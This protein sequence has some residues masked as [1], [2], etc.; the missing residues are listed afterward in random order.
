MRANGQNHQ[1]Q[2]AELLQRAWTALQ[3]D[4]AAEAERLANEILSEQSGH[5]EATKIAAS[6]ML[7]Q[8]RA[9]EVVVLLERIARSSRDPEVETQLAIALRQ[10]G[11]T[12]NSLIWLKR[13][14]KRKPPFAAAFHELGFVLNSLR[15]FDEAIAVLKQGIEAA[16]MMT[17][18][19]IQLGH[20]YYARPDRE[21][22]EKTF[23][24]A[25][26]INPDN[27]EAIHGLGSV[28]VDKGDYAGAAKLLRHAL[29]VNQADTE[30]RFGLA[31]CM[32]EL[33]QP[34]IAYACLRAATASGPG[35]YGIALNALASSG[36][37]RFWLRPSDAA[38]FF[39]GDR[40]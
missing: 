21:N 36:H 35:C 6:A 38:K 8:G 7:M 12:S 19:Q 40:E 26:A 17:Y 27:P 31:K 16:P 29:M 33:G 30:A 24:A 23:A 10:A 34:D 11:R 20:V 5:I 18:L 13:A 15:R 37:G 1:Q 25:L 3:N 22:A 2:L 39:K 4:R 32:L 14:I 9:D 28:L